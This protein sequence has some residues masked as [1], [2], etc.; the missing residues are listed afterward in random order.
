MD[1]EV[2]QRIGGDAQQVDS[3][4]TDWSALTYKHVLLPVWI[5]SY[6][7]KSKT[8]RV[9]VNAATGEVQGERPWS[10]L[11]I[12]LLVLALVGVVAAVAVI[13]ART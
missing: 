3:I 8:Y 6:R 10:W 12:A 7:W 2:R 13:D 9:V 4:D 11:K 1:L 5:A